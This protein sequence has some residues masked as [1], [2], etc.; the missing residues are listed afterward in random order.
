[1]RTNRSMEPL[2]PRKLREAARLE[3]DDC[4]KPGK[5]DHAALRIDRDVIVASTIVNSDRRS[6]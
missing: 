4:V 1:M 2:V 6:P 3:T 5:A